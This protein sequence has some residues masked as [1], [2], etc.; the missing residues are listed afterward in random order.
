MTSDDTVPK[1]NIRGNYPALLTIS[2]QKKKKNTHQ[3]SKLKVFHHNSH[4]LD[5]MQ[6]SVELKTV[7]NCKVKKLRS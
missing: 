2:P 1:Y 3:T 5:L 4:E 7:K 6:Q